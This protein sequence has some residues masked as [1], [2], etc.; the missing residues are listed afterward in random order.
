M[1]F[2]QLFVC[3]FVGMNISKTNAASI[4][5]LNRQF[6]HDE[7]LK[8]IYFGVKGQGH[9]STNRCR[10]TSLNCCGYC[11]LV[12]IISRVIGVDLCLSLITVMRELSNQVNSTSVSTSMTF[13]FCIL[14]GCW[15]RRLNLKRAS[16]SSLTS[17]VKQQSQR[18]LTVRKTAKAE[19]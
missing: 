19:F 16:S 8:P 7:S 5:K 10:R 9:E 4:T 15:L 6:F 18:L 17:A 11:L 13:I 14:S 1:R 12:I 2:S 3:L